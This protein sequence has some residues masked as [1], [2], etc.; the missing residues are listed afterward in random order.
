M[1]QWLF[2]FGCLLLLTQLSACHMNRA[3]TSNQSVQKTVSQASFERPEEIKELFNSAHTSAVF[4]TYDSQ[5][6]NRYGN[7]LARA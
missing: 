6:F 3:Q 4:I 1:Q 5:Q 7:A 2:Y